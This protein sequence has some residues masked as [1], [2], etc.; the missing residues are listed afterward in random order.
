MT[1]NVAQSIV[2][3]VGERDWSRRARKVWE[4]LGKELDFRRSAEFK[5]ESQ[6]KG[7]RA[8][9]DREVECTGHTERSS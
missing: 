6:E 3:G 5:K 8:K 9:E 4:D 2:M 7:I 1:L